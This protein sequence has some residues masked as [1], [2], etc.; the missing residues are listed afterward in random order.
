MRNSIKKAIAAF[1]TWFEINCGWF[2]VNGMKEVNWI[3]YLKTKYRN[4]RSKP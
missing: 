4:E 2:F 1:Y 3:K